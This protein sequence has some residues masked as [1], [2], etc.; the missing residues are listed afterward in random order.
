ME[1][2]KFCPILQAASGVFETCHEECA[3]WSKQYQVL[4]TDEVH[5]ACALKLMAEALSSVK[6]RGIIQFYGGDMS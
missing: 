1:N 4:P 3:W 6:E 2:R 5:Y